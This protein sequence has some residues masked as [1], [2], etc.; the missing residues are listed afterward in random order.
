[1]HNLEMSEAQISINLLHQTQVAHRGCKQPNISVQFIN[2]LLGCHFIKAVHGDSPAIAALS[3]LQSLTALRS[4]VSHARQCRRLRQSIQ[5]LLFKNFRQ[6]QISINTWLRQHIHIRR[7]HTF[8]MRI[9]VPETLLKKT[10]ICGN[11]KW[12][13]TT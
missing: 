11:A 6:T 12:G 8:G 10:K 9:S 2:N 1:M 13:S 4:E 3:P 5:W 7:Y